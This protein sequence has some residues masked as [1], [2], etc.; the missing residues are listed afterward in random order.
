M[1]LKIASVLPELILFIAPKITYFT[2]RAYFNGSRKK[3]KIEIVY[4]LT[5]LNQKTYLPYNHT[6]ITF[7]MFCK[8]IEKI[9]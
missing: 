7:K 6:Y 9:Y 8:K 2:N 4:L 3:M 5:F 1:R